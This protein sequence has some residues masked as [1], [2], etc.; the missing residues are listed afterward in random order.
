MTTA[1]ADATVAVVEQFAAAHPNLRLIRNDHRGKG[2]AVRTGMLAA[3]G[4]YILFCDADLATP[5]EEWHKVEQLL[6]AGADVVIGS[7]EGLG[8]E[9]IGEPWHRHLMGRVNN[10]LIRLVALRGIQDTQCG[11]KAFTYNAAQRIFRAVR[12]YGDDAPVLTGAAVTGFDVEVLFL[13]RK[14]GLRLRDCPVVWHYG[15]ETKV[16]PLRDSARNLL[17]SSQGPLERPAGRLPPRRP[18]RPAA[19]AAAAGL[20]A[21]P[22]FVAI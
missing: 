11:F 8:A 19:G 9:R 7:R 17:R 1:A 4:E 6:R 18:P 16:D 13:G 22:C 14:M 21:R 5:I 20:G 3:T 12:L 2:Y 10:V 15:Q